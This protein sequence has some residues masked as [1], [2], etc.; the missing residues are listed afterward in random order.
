MI[1]WTSWS[2]NYAWF[3]ARNSLNSYPDSKSQKTL[4]LAAEGPKVTY[5]ANLYH[6]TIFPILAHWVQAPWIIVN[7]AVAIMILMAWKHYELKKVCQKTKKKSKLKQQ[8]QATKNHF[9]SH[10]CCAD[11]D[12]RH[13]RVRR[14]LTWFL[15]RSSYQVSII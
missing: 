11:V 4:P 6:C 8:H 3:L 10:P 13:S 2:T 12:Y 1:S 15:R 9:S 7:L 5:P 14:T